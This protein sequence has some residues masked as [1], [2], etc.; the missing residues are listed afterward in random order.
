MVGVTTIGAKIGSVLAVTISCSTT[1]HVLTKKI[2]TMKSTQSSTASKS[3]K[4]TVL[5]HSI[6]P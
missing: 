6:C 3:L 2:N 4:G 1:E 5:Y